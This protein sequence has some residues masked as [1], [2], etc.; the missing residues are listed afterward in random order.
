MRDKFLLC[1]S[2]FLLLHLSLPAKNKNARVSPISH[3]AVSM[4]S[5]HSATPLDTPN[6]EVTGF[7]RG[8]RDSYLSDS[9]FRYNRVGGRNFF[10][11]LREWISDF[12]RELFSVQKE[13]LNEKSSLII[14]RIIS[15]LVFLAIFFFGIKW[16]INRKGRWLTQKKNTSIDFDI[17]DAEQLI[18]NADFEQLILRTEKKGDRR[19]SIRLYYLW[20]L[21]DLKEKNL[22]V[23]LPEK[24]N[25]DYFFELKDEVLRKKFGH[26][27]YF[28]NYIWYGEFE[29]SDADYRVAKNEFLIY[30]KNDSPNG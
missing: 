16:L 25:T 5:S 17:N 27:S 6:R 13:S 21:R 2:L 26:L 22:I 4:Q 11:V 7:R 19:Q 23:W 18:E 15:G 24:T 28:Y 30:L 9:E 1:L 10:E 14:F 20:L 3:P 8:F 12:L 29:I